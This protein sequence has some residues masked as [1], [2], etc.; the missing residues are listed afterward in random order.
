MSP[1]AEVGQRRRWFGSPGQL[2]TPQSGTNLG[3]ASGSD[4]PAQSQP[5]RP[6]SAVS[7]PQPDDS[8]AGLTV[9]AFNDTLNLF[10]REA[11]DDVLLVWRAVAGGDAEHHVYGAVRHGRGVIRLELVLRL[12]VLGPGWSNDLDL[13][14]GFILF[15]TSCGGHP[16]SP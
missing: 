3:G 8:S 4:G 6:A 14:H 2:S 10:C 7:Q 5:G 13:L 11:R 1:G 9:T 15:V 16:G 12:E